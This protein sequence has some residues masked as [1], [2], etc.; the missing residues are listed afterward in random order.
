MT[1]LVDYRSI[2]QLQGFSNVLKDFIVKN[3]LYTVIRGKK[4]VNV[5]G[6]EFAGVSLGVSANVIECKKVKSQE[7][8]IKYRAVA[9]LLDIAGN[10]IGLGVA[11]CSN[12]EV[13]KRSFEEYAIAS[14]AQ[15]RAIGKAY[16]NK[17]AFVIKMAG[18]EPTPSEEE[19]PPNILKTE[20]AQ[21]VDNEAGVQSTTIGAQIREIVY[22]AKTGAEKEKCKK[23]I[24]KALNNKLIT[25]EQFTEYSKVIGG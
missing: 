18:Y 20:K 11:I 2:N 7:N 9:E 25:D 6:W 5:E 14:M 13:N 17:F 1:D 15:T 19:M 8:E 23:M 16:R 4:Y 12:M 10:R 24:S 3:N 22:N 21:R